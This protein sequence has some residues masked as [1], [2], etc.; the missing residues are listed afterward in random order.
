MVFGSLHNAHD[1]AEN[2][3][4]PF[5]LEGIETMFSIT[6]NT[7]GPLSDYATNQEWIVRYKIVY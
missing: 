1:P 2:Y 3:Y 5:A 4:F 7:A 6:S